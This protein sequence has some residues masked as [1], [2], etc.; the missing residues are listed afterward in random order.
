MLDYALD[1]ARSF[2][3]SL[4]EIIMRSFTKAL[5]VSLACSGA[6]VAGCSADIHDNA[7]KIDATLTVTANTNVQDVAPGSTIPVTI[8]ASNVFPVAPGQ[9]PPPEHMS[10]AVYFKFFVD[11]DTSDSAAIL[12]TAS[13]SANVQIKS[14]T[15]PGSHKLLCRMYKHD[16]TPTQTT[17]SLDFSVKAMGTATVSSDAG[18]GG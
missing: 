9:T 4:E 15:A 16:D 13:L 3:R 6:A 11:D 8:N 14:D 17:F 5:L 2:A 1:E 10:D 18:V 7:V 12:V